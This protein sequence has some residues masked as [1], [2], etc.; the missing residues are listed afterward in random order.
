MSMVRILRP[1]G[2]VAGEISTEQLAF[3]QAQF[4]REHAEDADWYVDAP[5]LEMLEES[6]ADPQLVSVLR[7]AVEPAGGG[8]IR[9]QVG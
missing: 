5:T 6:G 2:S 4:E 9:W 7:A 3:L 8:E 1:D